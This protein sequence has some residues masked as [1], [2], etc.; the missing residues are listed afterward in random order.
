MPQPYQT[1]DAAGNAVIA[2]WT[3]TSRAHDGKVDYV[4]TSR[5]YHR[6]R[7]RVGG[8]HHSSHPARILLHLATHLILHSVKPKPRMT[9]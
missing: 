2:I 7:I 5:H 8:H 1:D 3:A 6:L 9:G 4:G